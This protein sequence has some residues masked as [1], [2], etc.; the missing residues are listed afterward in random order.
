M[1]LLTHFQNK[2]G[3]TI[4]DVQVWIGN[5][6]PNC[7][8][9][10]INY[11]CWVKC[12]TT[13]VNGP[14][15]MEWLIYTRTHRL[16]CGRPVLS[17]YQEVHLVV[18]LICIHTLKYIFVQIS[19]YLIASNSSSMYVA[20]NGINP[21]VTQSVRGLYFRLPILKVRIFISWDVVLIYRTCSPPPPPPPHGKYMALIATLSL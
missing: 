5:F 9:N 17:L 2:N 20:I 10:V 1:K 13:L 3:C 15:I 4:V 21:S 8:K 11:Q 14:L 7:M 16:R 6:I 18:K 19:V 12:W